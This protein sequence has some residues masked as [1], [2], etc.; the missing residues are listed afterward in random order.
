MKTVIS[1]SIGFSSFVLL[2]ELPA[3]SVTIP[4]NLYSPSSNLV[5]ST[6][7]LQFAMSDSLVPALSVVNVS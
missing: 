6:L 3:A 1:F 5:V 4:R 2:P 7:K